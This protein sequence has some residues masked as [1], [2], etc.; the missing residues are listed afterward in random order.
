MKTKC[1]YLHEHNIIIQIGVTKSWKKKMFQRISMIWMT[2]NW[3]A[4]INQRK[5]WEKLQITMIEPT[6]NWQNWIL[7]EWIHG[8][9]V[10][11]FLVSFFFFTFHINFIDSYHIISHS[12]WFF[13]C[14]CIFQYFYE[15]V[16]SGFLQIRFFLISGLQ[17]KTVLY[18]HPT[19]LVRF[20]RVRW[21]RA[22][23][24]NRLFSRS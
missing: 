4:Y 7:I 22:I 24:S 10:V 13:V 9:V 19:L 21:T 23:A 3:K 11:R 2:V 12:L 20:I 5:L 8:M 1:F 6:T 14:I 18:C 17:T 15:C 16:V